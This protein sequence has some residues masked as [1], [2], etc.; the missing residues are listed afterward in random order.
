MIGAILGAI[1][2]SLILRFRFSDHWKTA[3]HHARYTQRSVNL[4]PEHQRC[5]QKSRCIHIYS[6][7][8]FHTPRNGVTTTQT[9]NSAN[10]QA[11]GFLNIAL[12]N[13]IEIRIVPQNRNADQ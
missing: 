10:F 13:R 3:T 6:F 4:E 11:D 5:R 7:T 1:A 2:F 8:V 9:R 12:G